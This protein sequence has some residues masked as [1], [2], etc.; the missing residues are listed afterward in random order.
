L[1]RYPVKAEGGKQTAVVEPVPDRLLEQAAGLLSGARRALLYVGLGAAGTEL[2]QLAERLEAP[3]ATTF[4]GKGVFPET[5]PLALWPGYG[6]SAPP[7]ARKIAAGWD[8]TLGLG[9]RLGDV[10]AG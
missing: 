2:V 6:A 1:F 7:F 8:V 5:H 4:Q 3:V 10:A 9:C